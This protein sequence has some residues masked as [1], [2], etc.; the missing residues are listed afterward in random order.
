MVSYSFGETKPSKTPFFPS[1]NSYKNKKSAFLCYKNSKTIYSS[2]G[3]NWK[4]NFNLQTLIKRYPSMRA[5]GFLRDDPAT[6]YLC[7]LTNEH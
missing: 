6:V 3:S 5:I 1:K 2:N 7:N 4:Q